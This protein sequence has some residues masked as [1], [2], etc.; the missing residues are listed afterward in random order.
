MSWRT[1]ISLTADYQE[2]QWQL[3]VYDHL[4]CPDDAISILG[5]IAIILIGIYGTKQTL[6][7]LIEISE[8]AKNITENNLNVR[9]EETGNKD[10]L[11]Q[12]DHVLNQMIRKL[13]QPL[14]TRNALFLTLHELRIPWRWFLGYIDILSDWGKNDPQL[15]DERI[16]AIRDEIQGMNKMV[17]DLLLIY[18]DWK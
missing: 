4:I 9:I 16:E 17:E 13:S 18:A 6:K 11:D 5:M 3:R 12:L 2:P 1:A 7:P 14:I 15:R 8:T 10:E